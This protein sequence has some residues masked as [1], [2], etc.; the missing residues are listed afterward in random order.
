MYQP[1]KVYPL[2]VTFGRAPKREPTVNCLVAGLGAL[3][4][5]ELKVTVLVSGVAGAG[6]GSVFGAGALAVQRAKIVV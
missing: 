4:P 3:P 5:L 1:S 6:A 2:L